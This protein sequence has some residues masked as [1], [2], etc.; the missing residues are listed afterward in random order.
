MVLTEDV[1]LAPKIVTM[2][3]T[4]VFTVPSVIKA[5][6]GTKVATTPT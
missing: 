4:E 6:G 3:A 1:H 2:T 5:P